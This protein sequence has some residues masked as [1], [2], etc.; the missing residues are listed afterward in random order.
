MSNK[1]WC[2]LTVHHINI[3][4]K[5][6][7]TYFK[8][9]CHLFWVLCNICIFGAFM[10]EQAD[11]A[12]FFTWRWAWLFAQ[13]LLERHCQI[14]NMAWGYSKLT[15]LNHWPR[16]LTQ[17]FYSRIST[18]RQD[19]NLDRRPI[20]ISFLVFTFQFLRKSCYSLTKHI[21]LLIP[22]FLNFYFLKYCPQCK[23]DYNDDIAIVKDFKPRIIC[24]Q[25]ITCPVLWF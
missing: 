1:D 21:R 3:P 6:F 5:I 9:A 4:A 8:F 25:M 18:V 11:S 10:S 12:L 13:T 20:L 15:T 16:V 22:Y 17:L 23:P 14:V 2:T 24:Y 7:Q 19:S